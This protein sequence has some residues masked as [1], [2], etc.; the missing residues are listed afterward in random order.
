MGS[1][2]TVKIGGLTIGGGNPV[3]VQSMLNIEAHDAAGCV[4]QAKELEAAGCEIIRATVPD[5]E[6]VRT[7]AAL[8]EAFAAR[9]THLSPRLTTF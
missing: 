4:A 5:H 1:R 6:A 7:V 8:K 2:K 3:A 9:A